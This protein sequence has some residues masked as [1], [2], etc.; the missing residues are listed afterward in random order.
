MGTQVEL[1]ASEMILDHSHFAYPCRLLCLT[2]KHRFEDHTSSFYGF[3]S[4]GTCEA[5]F[6]G[7][8]VTLGA[9]MHFAIPGDLELDAQGKTVIFQRSG[10]RAL[11]QF[12]GPVE[13][14]G[15]LSYI[16]NSHASVLI[17]PARLGDPVLNLLVFPPH[18][19]QTAHIHPTSRLGVVIRGSG[20]FVGEQK[21]PLEPGKVFSLAPFDVHCFHSGKD[22]LAVIAFH[23][24]SD[25]GPTD[26]S[27]PMKN[28]TY[29][30]K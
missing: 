23:P 15:R 5:R 4:E 26:E 13:R 17:P 22:G 29:L 30:V 9:N 3:V 16:D 14:N 28:R 25:T 19:Q 2:G 10:Y 11:P 24:D 18:I 1:F 7:Q 27:H 20:T 6:Q 8:T 21:L 12:G